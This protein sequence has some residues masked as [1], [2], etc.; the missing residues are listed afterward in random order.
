MKCQDI[1][2]FDLDTFD[3]CSAPATHRHGRRLYCEPHAPEGSVKLDD[4]VT[5]SQMTD[6]DKAAEYD[7]NA[8]YLRKQGWVVVKEWQNPA[9]G[10][11]ICQTWQHPDDAPNG[12]HGMFS[13]LRVEAFKDAPGQGERMKEIHKS[14]EEMKKRLSSMP[15][16]RAG[17]EGCLDCGAYTQDPKTEPLK[18]EGW[19]PS[20]PRRR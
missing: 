8:E 3:S 20:L 19:C 9:E 13:A 10:D 5:K 1:D 15:T 14:F 17:D 16:H 18:H 6:A 12:F 7:R 11:R 4:F 2:S